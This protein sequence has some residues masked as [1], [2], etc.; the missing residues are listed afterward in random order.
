MVTFCL[1][2]LSASPRTR[3]AAATC[4]APARAAWR[5]A[6][7]P[8]PTSTRT[9]ASCTSSTPRAFAHTSAAWSVS[10]HHIVLTDRTFLCPHHRLFCHV[11]DA[12][13]GADEPQA[14]ASQCSAPGFHL[15]HK[16][17]CTADKC[18]VNSGT[19]VHFLVELGGILDSPTTFL[20]AFHVLH[21]VRSAPRCGWIRP[22]SP[23]P[24]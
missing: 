12:L 3:S 13:I 8:A 16:A 17:C 9:S 20:S 7:R 11:C 15:M 14:C 2:L 21:A 6:S 4:V 22:R 18:E 19:S 10:F 1:W 23:A 5:R 24:R